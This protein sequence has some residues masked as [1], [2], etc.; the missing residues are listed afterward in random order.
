[1]KLKFVDALIAIGTQ[2]EFHTP[3]ITIWANLRFNGLCILDCTSKDLVRVVSD[4]Y[5]PY[6]NLCID[7]TS[8]Y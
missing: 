6:L 2:Q 3:S 8:N 7:I 4:I 1:M 5:K